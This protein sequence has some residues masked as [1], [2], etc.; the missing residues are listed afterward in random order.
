MSECLL[1][2]LLL[3]LLLLLLIL[4]PLLLR[5]VNTNISP[6]IRDI[7][8]LVASVDL[9]LARHEQRYGLLDILDHVLQVRLDP[10]EQSPDGGAAIAVADVAG[11]A[12]SA[13]AG[14]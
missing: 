2:L 10:P 13:S 12:T 3:L 7:D 9:A 14:L 5:W 8:E 6:K 11:R 4:L 1:I